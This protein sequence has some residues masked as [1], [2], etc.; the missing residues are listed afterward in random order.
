VRTS[1]R[2][3][4]IDTRQLVEEPV[5]R[6]AKALLVLL[7]VGCRLASRS[8]LMLCKRGAAIADAGTLFSNF[9]AY[10]RPLLRKEA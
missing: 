4:G 6:R 9:N 1:R 3:R 10:G 5:R 2:P 8:T 7:P